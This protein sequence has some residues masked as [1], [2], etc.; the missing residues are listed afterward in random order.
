MKR[1]F[2]EEYHDNKYR[3]AAID[4]DRIYNSDNPGNLANVF[5][6]SISERSASYDAQIYYAMA[7]SIDALDIFADIK[8]LYR[9][10]K[11]NTWSI[12]VIDNNIANIFQ[13]VKPLSYQD[14]INLYSECHSISPTE[15]IKST[16]SSLMSFVLF[17][18]NQKWKTG[19]LQRVIDCIVKPECRG[20]PQVY[21]VIDEY[22][23]KL[24]RFKFESEGPTD[25]PLFE[26]IRL[27]TKCLGL[28]HSHDDTLFYHIPKEIQGHIDLILNDNPG[29]KSYPKGCLKDKLSAIFYVWSGSYITECEAGYTLKVEPDII[30]GLSYM[31]PLLLKPQSVIIIDSKL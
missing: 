28:K 5:E 17:S 19:I 8:D 9:S 31:Q 22:Y 20:D 18:N 10:C 21:A 4:I 11:L 23:R 27:I 7:P 29:F 24:L 1:I 25:S 12:S 6:F 16:S 2:I 14:R 26:S 13:T 3:L 30:L 15:M